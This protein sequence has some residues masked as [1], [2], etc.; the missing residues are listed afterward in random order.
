M[1]TPLVAL[2]ALLL[3]ASVASCGGTL[4]TAGEDPA[5][6]NHGAHGM[7]LTG[8][9]LYEHNGTLLSYL[10]SR[11]SGMVVDYAQQ[12]CPRVQLRGR[13]SLFGS[14][15]PI[16]YVD[17][18]RTA[19]SCVLEM[20]STRDL[21]RIEVYPMGVANRPGYEAH[22]NGLILVFVR[23]GRPLEGVS[24]EDRAYTV[25]APW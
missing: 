18:A 22:P 23:D 2:A 4:S 21:S 14:S 24:S 20:L 3:S 9:D 13:K 7:V 12:P 16:V 5:P 19:N 11:I 15:D 1:R 10:Y 6:A 25:N 17:G 8:P